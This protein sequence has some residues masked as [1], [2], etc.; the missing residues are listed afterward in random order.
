MKREG[1]HGKTRS[2]GQVLSL[3]Q[4][5]CMLDK[6][7]PIEKQL[8]AGGLPYGQGRSYGDA[9]L[10]PGGILWDTR[11]LDRLIHFDPNSGRL[12]CHPGVLLQDIQRLFIPR[13]Y[14][15]PV[16][17]GTQ[18]ITV[19]GA[20]ANDVHGK[21]HYHAGSFAHHVQS[22]TLAR[23]NG[24]TIYC[25]PQQEKEWFYATVGGLGLTGVITEVE[26]Q[27]KQA[28]GPWLQVET[29]PF[30]DLDALFALMQA[31]LPHWEHTVAWLD[32]SASHL[33]RGFL[34][35]A[36]PVKSNRLWNPSAKAYAVPKLPFSVVNKK[37]STWL[38]ALYFQR[39]KKPKS[40]VVDAESFLYPLDAISQW[41]RLYGP[42]GFFQYQCVVPMGQ[43]QETL[44]SLLQTMSDWG[45]HPS[46]SVIKAFG[47]HQSLGCLSFPKPG[48][49]F[50][51]DFPNKKSIPALFS[52]LDK[53]LAAAGG[54]LYL[55]KD[56]CMAKDFFKTSYPHWEQFMAYRDPGIHSALSQR[57]MGY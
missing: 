29:C 9:C 34:S 8:D 44:N 52:M 22:L 28:I 15:L 42:K 48:M 11:S 31:S 57:L 7:K 32:G 35:R 25:S 30:D 14:S 36:N 13:G 26:L 54:H 41:N 12:I 27:L 21:N 16:T 23:T 10:N 6:N 43:A 46:L 37:T 4:R 1:Y 51:F 53:H 55:A 45:E 20:V 19:G 3:E 39:N 50:A 2:W 17:P 33:V 24:Q 47:P 56:A 38:N 49:T 40:K 5:V 18:L